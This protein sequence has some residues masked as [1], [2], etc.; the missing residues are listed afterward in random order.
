MIC[1][2]SLKVSKF[3]VRNI[4]EDEMEMVTKN[5]LRKRIFNAGLVFKQIKI[6]PGGH[7]KKQQKFDSTWKA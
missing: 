6:Y 2:G 3:L 5:V 1:V 4:D 7:Q